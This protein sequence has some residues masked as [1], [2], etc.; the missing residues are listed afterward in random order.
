[1]V[2]RSTEVARINI[3]AYGRFISERIRENFH[4]L[5]HPHRDVLRVLPLVYLQEQPGASIVRFDTFFIEFR[6]TEGMLRLGRYEK[7]TYP[8][9]TSQHVVIQLDHIDS[10]AKPVSFPP[11]TLSGLSVVDG[12]ERELTD[13]E[14]RALQ[15]SLALIDPVRDVVTWGIDWKDLGKMRLLDALKI[16][17]ESLEWDD[18]AKHA[19]PSEI[20]HLMAIGNLNELLEIFPAEV[21]RDVFGKGYR[22]KVF[23]YFAV[24]AS[25]PP[26][27]VLGNLG[28][29]YKLLKKEIDGKEVDINL[30]NF[31]VTQLPNAEQQEF[32]RLLA[33]GKDYG[34]LMTVGEDEAMRIIINPHI[35]RKLN[36]LVDPKEHTPDG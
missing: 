8:K 33:F 7:P 25:Y 4:G 18:L 31:A 35:S 21:L 3:A 20:S 2:N 16:P 6:L 23:K 15:R 27:P 12:I 34:I 13:Q 19:H 22:E 32:H 9:G 29:F 28:I 1:M 10:H 17:S 24:V 5:F 14:S 11:V 26:S 30:Q 36:E